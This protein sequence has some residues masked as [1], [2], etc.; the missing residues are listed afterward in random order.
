MI[1]IA[2][3]LFLVTPL[4]LGQVAEANGASSVGDQESSIAMPLDLII[5]QMGSENFSVR[6]FATRALIE[7][8]IT[9]DEIQSRLDTETLKE[10]QRQ[11][12][13]SAFRFRLFNAPRGALGIRMSFR[14]NANGRGGRVLVT[15]LLDDLPAREVLVLGDAIIRLDGI[16][17]TS[18][19][20][21][22]LHVQAK[23]PGDKVRLEIERP[24]VDEQGRQIL[25]EANVPQIENFEVDVI[26]GSADLLDDSNRLPS[27][28]RA[29]NVIDVSLLARIEERVRQSSVPLQV[30]P[31]DGVVI[32]SQRAKK[33]P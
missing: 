29:I 10:E 5:E 18:T 33:Q 30:I 26:L 31:L 4:T 15:D 19:S 13:M 27:Q 2:V 21:L 6:E 16:R 28:T 7:S 24:V 11:R 17:P 23:R 1:N 8:D 20:D 32:K 22:I 3:I 14:G 9:D 25:D 12:L